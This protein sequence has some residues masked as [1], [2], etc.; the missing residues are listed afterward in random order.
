MSFVDDGAFE[1]SVNIT[2][3]SQHPR[4]APNLAKSQYDLISDINSGKLFTNPGL[5]NTTA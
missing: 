2:Q 5:A 1:D 3:G 4:M